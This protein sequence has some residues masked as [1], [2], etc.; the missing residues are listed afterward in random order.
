MIGKSKAHVSGSHCLVHASSS[1]IVTQGIQFLLETSDVQFD[2]TGN[3][4]WKYHYGDEDK[5][6]MEQQEADA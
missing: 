6:E 4:K 5:I 2:E 1:F 3:K